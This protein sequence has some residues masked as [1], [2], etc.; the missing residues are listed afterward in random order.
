[1]VW[2]RDRTTESSVRITLDNQIFCISREDQV[3]EVF[4]C[5]CLSAPH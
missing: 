3:R 5:M 1:V 4:D 2:R